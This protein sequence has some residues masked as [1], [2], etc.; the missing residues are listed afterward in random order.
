MY[1]GVDTWGTPGKVGNGQGNA[2]F[3]LNAAVA[4]GTH[5]LNVDITL[6][7]SGAD[8]FELPGIHDSPMGGITLTF[9]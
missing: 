4:S 5:T 8:I 6:K 7:G 9:K 2:N 3:H 1:L